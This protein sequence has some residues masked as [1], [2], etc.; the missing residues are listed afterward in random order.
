VDRALSGTA[1][2]PV[3]EA[4]ARLDALATLMAIPVTQVRRS[5]LAAAVQS[6]DALRGSAEWHATIARRALAL[7]PGL[8][9]RTVADAVVREAEEQI[10]SIVLAARL[11]TA[12]LPDGPTA[13]AVRARV[14]EERLA[15][16]QALIKEMERRTKSRNDLPEFDEW[17]AFAGVRR[18]VDDAT[19]D[20]GSPADYRVVFQMAYYSLTSYAVRL[21]NIRTHRV[22]A[23]QVCGFLKDLGER[24][25]ATDAQALLQKNFQACAAN[26]LPRVPALEGKV[27]S[28]KRRMNIARAALFF[29]VAGSVVALTFAIPALDHSSLPSKGLLVAGAVVLLFVSL[30]VPPVTAHRLCE[31]SVTE[32][33][34]VVQITTG[35]F[36]A[37]FRDVR[38]AASR[39]GGIIALE[40]ARAPAW[41]PRKLWTW[42]PS[43]AL[44]R[45]Y[46]D[47]IMQRAHSK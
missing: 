14:R 9:E 30:V 32:D 27:L 4:A 2:R 33:G 12:W 24:A 13:A 46:A 21:I 16:A 28:H 3:A 23:R 11:P 39:P 7:S 36:V 40:L 10:V 8:D 20:A 15:R 18:A 25:N 31:I 29:V 35:R 38:A 26:R 22:L 47:L 34:L 41:L 6:V 37:L 19:L 1:P 45:E 43:V 42:A 5:D 17:R 44:S